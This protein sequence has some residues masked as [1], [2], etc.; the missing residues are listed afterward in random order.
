MECSDAG[1]IL[2]APVVRNSEAVVHNSRAVVHNSKAVV[3][4]SE[5]VV[6]DDIR[7]ETFM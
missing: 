1:L 5:A 6:R 7:R 2:E 4:N 3:H